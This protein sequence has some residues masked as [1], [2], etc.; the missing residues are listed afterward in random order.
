MSTVQEVEVRIGPD[1]KVRLH[2]RG[3]DGEAC[4]EVTREL[5]RHLG[6]RVADRQHTDEFFGI[7]VRETLGAGIR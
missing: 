5:E 2:V 4:L 3:V 7:G 6:G 1:G